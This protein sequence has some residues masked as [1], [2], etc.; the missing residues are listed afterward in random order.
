MLLL[1]EPLGA[2]DARL[3]KELQVELKAL[4]EEVGIT[5]V[6]VTHDQEEALTMS[7]RLAVMNDGPV[8]QGGTARRRSTRSP[9]RVFVADFLGVSNLMDAEVDRPRGRRPACVRVGDFALRARA[10]T[11]P[12]AATVKIVA[13]PERVTLS[14]ARARR[15]RQR[16]PG[17]RRAHRLRRRDGPGDRA[18]R[19]GRDDAVVGRQRRRRRELGAGHAGVRAH[20]ARR[21]ARARPSVLS[22]TAAATRRRIVG[23]MTG[24]PVSAQRVLL[25]ED[26]LSIAEPFALA[27]AR[28]GFEPLIARTAAE[29]LRLG[30][31]AKPDVVLLDLALPD[32]DGRDVCRE[33]RRISD[34]PIIMLT[35]R[36]T[37]T[38]RVVGLE[39]GADDYVVKPFATGEVISRIRAV[40]RRARGTG[41]PAAAEPRALDRR[42]P[43]ARPRA[44]A[45]R[46]SPARSSTSRAR[47]ST[48]SRGWRATPDASSRARR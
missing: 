10:A 24:G 38:D 6:F 29:A 19:N 42:R 3:R 11:S 31:E 5:F 1:D 44:R 27:L 18:P 30:V 8:E 26:E 32:G 46:G 23:D 17:M 37:V 48:C 15:P 41:G 7:D 20:A 16:L 25:V 43:A 13:R 39:L 34:V 4:Q 47:S 33:L 12:R 45:A 36:G 21:G 14:A 28:N 9:R 2:L 22:T 40:L 35:A